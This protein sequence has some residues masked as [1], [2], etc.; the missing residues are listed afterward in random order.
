[1]EDRKTQN[2]IAR[3]GE[4]HINSKGFG[5][6]SALE[7]GIRRYKETDGETVSK[8]TYRKE[9]TTRRNVL[10]TESNGMSSEHHSTIV[11]A[12][13]AKTSRQYERR[14][15]K[16]KHFETANLSQNSADHAK[17][18]RHALHRIG[19]KFHLKTNQSCPWVYFHRPSPTQPTK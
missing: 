15:K 10:K 6:V 8:K 14:K 18:L 16:Q 11:G 1:M 5:N 13:G 17:I 2:T 19:E 9:E 12:N 3:T 7:Q 4:F